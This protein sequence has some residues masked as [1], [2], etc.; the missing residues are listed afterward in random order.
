M[1]ATILTLGALLTAAVTPL[2]AQ[3]TSESS[4]FIKAVRDGD[5][6]K[7]TSLLNA[8]GSTVAKSRDSGT[9]ENAL[10]IVIKKPNSDWAGFL[11]GR[12]VDPNAP[13]KG[14]E[15]PLGLAIRLGK[16]EVASLLIKRGARVDG[17]GRGETPLII[18]VLA[19]SPQM[20]QM[21]QMLVRKGANPD[22]TDGATGYSAREYAARDRRGAS[23]LRA[24]DDKRRVSAQESGC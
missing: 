10:H 19:R 4:A 24:L 23:I 7:T 22:K 1:R 9:G 21:V 18:A 17:I 11:L 6:A 14:G 2:S 3:M 15:T 5:G 16:C 12:G 8:S 20:V 13:D